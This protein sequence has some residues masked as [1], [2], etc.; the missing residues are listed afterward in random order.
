MPKPNSPARPDSQTRR[1]L[2]QGLLLGGVAGVLSNPVAAAPT[3]PIASQGTAAVLEGPVV[4]LV[5]SA[6]NVNFSGK[7]RIATVI[8]GSIP[9]PTLKFREGDEVT[10]R[11]TNQLDVPTSL[12]W[13]GIILPYTMDGVPGWSH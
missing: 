4:D 12:H 2:L 9:A 11:V 8:N 7:A 13:H 5:V 1:Q 6:A 10:I 3:T